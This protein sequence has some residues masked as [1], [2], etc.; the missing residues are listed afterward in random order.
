VSH[1]GRRHEP[2]ERDHRFLLA[3]LLRE[4]TRLTPLPVRKTWGVNPSALDQG[5]T[6]TCVGHGWRNFLRCAPSRSEKSGPS[7]YDIYRAAVMRD[8]WSDN[9]DE[10]ALPDGDP[11]MDSGTSVRAG[12]KALAGFGR[13]TSYVWAFSLQ[14]AIEWVLTTGP[15]VLGTDWYSSFSSPDRHGIVRISPGAAVVGGHCYLLRGVDRRQALARCSNSWGD[16]WGVSGEFL[17]PFQV[18]ER[19]IRDRGECC[20]AV[21]KV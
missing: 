7:P 5:Q 17:L 20:S 19:L 2:D 21:E 15:L 12:A 10:S 9:D 16:G 1:L 8:S 3:S 18:L 14:P 4:P 6:G 11:G 13:L